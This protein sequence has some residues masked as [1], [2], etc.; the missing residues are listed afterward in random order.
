MGRVAEEACTELAIVTDEKDPEAGI[1]REHL[2]GGIVHGTGF[3]VAA[4]CLLLYDCHP[5]PVNGY[6]VT[7]PNGPW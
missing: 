4:P 1:R 5:R 2:K 6:W 3:H 7:D